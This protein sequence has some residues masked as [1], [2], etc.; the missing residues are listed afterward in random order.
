MNKKFLMFSFVASATIYSGCGGEKKEVVKSVITVEAPKQEVKKN[1]DE[2]EKDD[3][4]QEVKEIEK[5]E[6]VKEELVIPI[7]ATK[8]VSDIEIEL[9]GMPIITENIKKSV[10]EISRFLRENQNFKIVVNSHTDASGSKEFN[11]EISQQRAEFLGEYFYSL[12]VHEEQVEAE[13]LG[14]AN[15]L[16]NEEPA[17]PKNRRMSVY[18]IEIK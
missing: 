2:L 5:V 9:G 7:H 3:E 18:L 15:L 8:I 12:G 4:V 1:F 16:V 17:S 13:G 14:S 11:K 6:V 10:L